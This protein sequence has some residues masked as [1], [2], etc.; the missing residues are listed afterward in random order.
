M[1]II[2][3]GGAGTQIILDTRLSGGWRRVAV[4]TDAGALARL[5]D[6]ETLQIGTRTCAGTPAGTF[7]VGE[8]AVRES[9]GELEA[10]MLRDREPVVAVA[11]L[12][13]GTGTAVLIALVE[14]CAKHARPFRAAVTIPPQFSGAQRALALR[15]L[16]Q[17][18]AKSTVYEY[19]LDVALSGAN[20]GMPQILK[21]AQDTL[22]RHILT[23]ICE[24]PA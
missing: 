21:A 13:G 16:S 11:G 23:P 4:N 19:D 17:L 10:L 8:R 20:E 6:V 5:A 3:A 7:V 22:V 14:L 9:F 24:T 18:R 15:T 1:L 12:G 2:G